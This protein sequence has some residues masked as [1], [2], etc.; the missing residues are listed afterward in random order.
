MADYLS[1][2]LTATCAVIGYFDGTT[3]HLDKNCLDVI[4]DL[5]RYLKRDNDTHTIRRFLG[6]TRLL[7]TDLVKILIHHVKNIELW[8]VLL[9]LLINLTSSAFVI[10]NEQIPTEKTMYSLYQQ[11]ISYLQEY[12]AALSDENVW[13]AI[14]GR[15]GDLLSITTIERGEEDELTIERILVFIRNVLQVPPNDN[16]KRADNDATV[17]DEVLFAFHASGMV[18]ILLFIVSNNQEQHY[19]MQVLEIISLMLREQNASLLAASGLQRSTAERENDEASLVALRQKELREKT[20]KVKKYAGSRHSRFGGTYVVENMKAIGENQMI[21]HQPYQKIEALEFGH[22]KKRVKRRK[23]KMSLQDPKEERTSAI[24]VRLFLKEF[25]V[26]FLSGAYNPV[27]RFTKSCFISDTHGHAVETA[28]YLWALRFF[29]EF[30]RHYKFQ[31]KYVSETISTEVFYLVQRQMEQYYE[32]IIVDKKKTSLWSRRLHLGLKAYQELLNTL[33]VM[34]KSTDNGVRESSKI[35]KSN[36]FYVPEYRETILSQLLCFD[37][38]KMS[39]QYLVDLITTVHIFLKMLEHFCQKGQRSLVIQKV[40]P[41]RRKAEKRKKKSTQENAITAPTLEERWDTVGPELSAVMRDAVIPVVVPFDATLDTPIDDQKADAMKR[42]QKLMRQRNLEQA[43]GLLRAAREIW[44]ENDCFGKVDIPPEEEF[45]ALREIFFADLGVIED[46]MAIQ[47]TINADEDTENSVNREE[48]EEEEDE[49]EEEEEA[50]TVFQEADFKLGE[51]LQRFANVKIVKALALLMQQFENNTVEVNHYV[52]KMLHRIAWNCKMPGMIFQ[53]SIFRIF[54]RILESKDPAHKEL[55]KFAVFI[56]RRFIEVAQKNRKSYMELLF[57]K[58]TRDATEIVD[59][60]NAET[61]NKKVSRATWTEAEEDELRTLFMEHQ[62]NK[63]P[64]DLIDWI[65]EHVINENRTRRIIIKKLKEMC[66]IVNS[67]GVRAEV[68]KRLPKE[69]SEEEIA[70]LTEL[71]TQLKDD[72]DP[73]DLIFTGLRIKRPKPKIKEKLLELGLAQDR[74][75]LRKKRSRKS[76]HGKSSWETQAASNSDGNESSATDDEDGEETRKSSK[77][78]GA[79]RRS[80]EP[81]KKKQQNRRKLPTIVYTDAQLSGLLKDVIDR[82]MRE[83]LEWIKE[84]LQDI[85]DDRDEESSEGIPLVPLTDYSSA[86]MDSPSFQKLLRAMGFVPPA[87]AQESYW[88]IPANMLTAT[89]QKRCK[90]IGDALAGE[91]IVE[92]TRKSQSDTDERGDD[93]ED[94]VDVFESVKKFFAPRESEPS[95]SKQSES[96]T[97]IQFSKKSKTLLTLDE[98]SDEAEVIENNDEVKIAVKPDKESIVRNRV[99]VLDD[100]SE[101]E[102]EIE[103]DIDD[104]NDDIKRDRSDSSS[105][106]DK[107]STKKRR[108]IDSD[109][110]IVEPL[111]SDYTEANG[112][113]VIISDDEE[114]LPNVRSERPTLSRVIISDEED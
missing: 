80:E 104:K 92:E 109:E 59:G 45:L 36:I 58:T 56:I 106:T 64:Q 31:V 52:T 19:H 67:K 40:K 84:S 95:T 5:I 105:D 66:L 41:K 21:C 103:R 10:Y 94:D 55:Q 72:D 62:T 3:Y 90:L 30:N 69:W 22:N 33:M 24:S 68:Q 71:W 32:M 4:K 42:I 39:R 35:I 77:R 43:V 76:N 44:P 85:L 51:F 93:S 28:V 46:Q 89:L 111:R 113:P 96:S 74:R 91:F 8:D 38:V 86:A 26:E 12:K 107:P 83:A 34:D 50:E 79:P 25:C 63:Y 49:D 60:Y 101:S 7:Q 81:T 27:M 37:E 102:M 70:Q 54:Q 48:N 15:L 47:E 73:V 18:D 99:R 114:S 78:G 108:L 23:D 6:Q 100:S 97:K 2:E 75:E 110:E 53:A 20:D 14:A 88:R 87:D 57:W 11:I 61:T 29:M 1:A 13:L 9:R 65:L 82:N 17:H 98:E 112:A 16:D